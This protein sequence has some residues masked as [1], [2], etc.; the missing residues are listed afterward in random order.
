MHTVIHAQIGKENS[1]LHFNKKICSIWICTPWGQ[2]KHRKGSLERLACCFVVLYLPPIACEDIFGLTFTIASLYSLIIEQFQHK[3]WF[4]GSNEAAWSHLALA[5]TC[6]LLWFYSFVLLYF[7]LLSTF[8]KD[9][10]NTGFTAQ[11]VQFNHRATLPSVGCTWEIIDAATICMLQ[12]HV[13][14]V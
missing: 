9:F 10:F 6:L 8:P 2:G 13:S 14:T 4:S 11:G 12:P 1:L 5:K 3:I 7:L